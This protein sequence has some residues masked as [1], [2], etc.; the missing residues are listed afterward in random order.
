MPEEKTVN[1]RE[2]VEQDIAAIKDRHLPRH[3]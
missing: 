3:R 2:L 1:L